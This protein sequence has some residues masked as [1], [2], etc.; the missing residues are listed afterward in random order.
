[1]ASTV[2]FTSNDTSSYSHTPLPL[3]SKL[4]KI[5]NSSEAVIQPSGDAGA[6]SIKATSSSDFEDDWPLDTMSKLFV[7]PFALPG[8]DPLII[9]L[10]IELIHRVA[11]FL[12]PIWIKNLSETCH[13]IRFALSDQ[14]ANRVWYEALP[15]KILDEPCKFQ[16]LDK[17][18]ERL[19]EIR[20]ERLRSE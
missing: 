5:A 13:G 9:H 18:D 10:P 19:K 14:V 8:D 15:R 17:I 11:E 7:T 2:S 16:C 12:A 4:E 6:D 20:L 3:C 1:M